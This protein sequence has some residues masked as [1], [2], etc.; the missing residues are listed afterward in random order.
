MRTIPGEY[1]QVYETPIRYSLDHG[2]TKTGYFW[3]TSRPVAMP[4]IAGETAVPQRLDKVLPT[5]F[6]GTAQCSDYTA[7]GS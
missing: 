1:V 5:D 3:A 4:S 6:Q 2:K 7:Y